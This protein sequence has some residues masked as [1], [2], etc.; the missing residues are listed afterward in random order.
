M[1]IP[2]P[3]RFLYTNNCKKFT[4]NYKPLQIY[5]VLNFYKSLYRFNLLF[6]VPVYQAFLHKAWIIIV[7]SNQERGKS[8]SHCFPKS[9]YS[10]NIYGIISSYKSSWEILVYIQFY[11]RNDKLLLCYYG[12]CGPSKY[13]GLN[14]CIVQ[15]MSSVWDGL[16]ASTHTILFVNFF[17]YF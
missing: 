11:M 9:W 1:K 16:Y 17:Q 8:V 4:W 13:G 6:S 3:R 12:I 2:K 14:F 7:F 10:F 15:T 5:Y